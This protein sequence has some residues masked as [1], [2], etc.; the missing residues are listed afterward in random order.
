MYFVSEQGTKQRWML[1]AV[2]AP[3][4][5][6][7][8]PIEPLLYQQHSKLLTSSYRTSLYIGYSQRTVSFQK[9]EV[10]NNKKM[11]WNVLIEAPS[12]GYVR[13]GSCHRVNQ[14]SLKLTVE[15]EVMQESPIRVKVFPLRG[16]A[17]LLLL[18]MSLIANTSGMLCPYTSIF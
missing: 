8:I 2:C 9:L 7:E 1:R 17:L 12:L 11:I 3:Y 4:F 15:L 6:M 5:C 10:I 16:M 18:L 14:V 13:E